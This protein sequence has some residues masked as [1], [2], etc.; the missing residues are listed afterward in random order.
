M[1]RA[2]RV[3]AGGAVI[4]VA[5]AAE[6]AAA[7]SSWW[8]LWQA[9]SAPS[10]TPSPPQPVGN[11]AFSVAQSGPGAA[12][13]AG[14][15]DRIEAQMRTLT[16]QLE[17]LSYQLRQLQDQLKRMQ[18]DTEYRFGEL[19]GGARPAKRPAASVATPAPAPP[20]N[21]PDAIAA[22]AG[23][24]APAPALAPA[25]ADATALGPP[26]RSL[27]TLTL[28]APADAGDQPID[29][30]SIA[31]GGSAPQPTA[32]A[33]AAPAS[34]SPAGQ[35]AGPA[36]APVI[37][38]LGSARGDYDQAYNLV[39]AGDYGRA[40]VALRQFLQTYPQDVLAP[41][42]QYWL[43]ES[44]FARG[45][46]REAADEFLAGYK[47]YPKSNKG[48]DTL[49][50]LGLSLAGL[51][52]RAAACSTYTQVLKQYPQMSNAMRQRVATEQASASC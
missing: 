25:P 35:A 5:L 38:S 50:K 12:D 6:P 46:Y 32:P 1:T 19:E 7:Q 23:D 18:E 40:E 15:F 10:A 21:N 24:Q 14:R 45:K 16:G 31:R 11:D 51:G 49:L 37:A 30:S 17:D 34:A 8:K 41:D 2:F 27:G 4:A 48:P 22:P 44:M 43:G 52:E 28:D 33:S 26:P 39:L 42:A 3:L 9:P 47:A 20:R 13:S 29:L 36:P